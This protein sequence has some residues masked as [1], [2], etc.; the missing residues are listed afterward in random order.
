MILVLVATFMLSGVAGLIYE[1]VW[2]R[3][4]GLF[5]GHSAYAQVIVLVIFLGGMSLGAAAV[6]QRSSRVTRPLFWYAGIEMI[7]GVIGL[8]FHDVFVQVTQLAYDTLFPALG[9]GVELQVAKWGIAALLILPQS[10]LLGMTF[11]MMS[12]GALRAAHIKPEHSGRLLAV[13]YFANSLGAAAGGVLAGFVFIP[14]AGLPGTLY[15]AAILNLVVALV[16]VLA[17]WVRRGR[18]VVVTPAP[19]LGDDGDALAPDALAGDEDSEATPAARR[20]RRVL[21]WVAAGTAVAS[22]VYEIAWI[23][24]LSLVLGAATHSFELML[25]AFIL[26]LALGA[27]WVR[28]RADTF[29]EPV[30]ALGLVQVLMGTLAVATM[31]LYIASFSWLAQLLQALAPS[32]SGYELFTVAKYGLSLVVMLPATF[33][34][35]ITLPLI[36][37]L[38][39][40][41][42]AGER[43]IGTVYAVNTLGSIVGAAFAALVLMP[44]LG[45]KWLLITGAVIDVGFGVALLAGA[46]D[47]RRKATDLRLVAAS[48]A[49]VMA[50][51]IGVRFDRLLLASGVYRY[52]TA[53]ISPEW[54]SMFYADGRTATVSA[55]L[56]RASGQRSLSTNG[57]PDA[58]LPARWML[59]LTPDFERAEL[60]G[61]QS[62]QLLLPLITLAYQPHA[63]RVAAIGQGSGMSS[64]LLLG[65]DSIRAM[66]TIEIEPMMIAGS[67]AIFYPANRRVFTDPRA[68]FII[69]DAKSVFASGGEKY[70]LILSEPSNP[71]V[72]G[73]SGL[74]TDQFYA[75]V[76]TSLSEHGVLGQ[77]LHLY[78]TN[79]FLV[80][81]VLAA[82]HR[83]F[84][85]YVIHMVSS[86]DLLIVA[87][88]SHEMPLPD[89]SVVSQRGI[90]EDLRRVLP[91]TPRALDA[92]WLADREVLGAML[93]HAPYNSDYFPILDL[94]TERARFLKSSATGFYG[95]AQDRF[96]ITHAMHARR[97][98]FGRDTIAPMD[99]A[100]VQALAFGVRLKAAMAKR[101]DS[102]SY[103]DTFMPNAIYQARAIAALGASGTPP[104]D[105]R[106]WISRV[107][108]VEEVLHGGTAGVADSAFYRSVEA[109][110]VRAKAPHGARA[111]V[112][113]M[114]GVAAWDW[115]AVSAQVD[116]LM[117]YERAR[118]PWVGA[119]LLRSAG[120]VARLQL[121]D[122]AGARIVFDRLTPGLPLSPLDVRTAL[123]DGWIRSAAAGEARRTGQ[124]PPGEVPR[125]VVPAPR[126]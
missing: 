53:E 74:F 79:D 20:F 38:L 111:G 93:A 87:S 68:R 110:L 117:H 52:A 34:A 99:M 41:H 19:A 5:V 108:D 102:S 54:R 55:R 95:L 39:L 9:A 15:A 100:R 92:T 69:D 71:W 22:F 49:F 114:R 2:S 86:T 58:S 94:G 23:R 13:L 50:A 82:V 112:A 56:D 103:N 44:L 78:E 90:A 97:E 66:H 98:S 121:G 85:S 91:L 16:V 3:Y 6:A 48:L 45:L 42:G 18:A 33:C 12:A 63:R 37:R 119:S 113:F 60:R 123:L 75:R 72:S 64:H 47:G 116:T 77:W 61:D 109:Y 67:R 21:L 96:S 88:P 126:E 30:R 76:R 118:A 57:K 59:P 27:W 40:A 14:M 46:A 31:P 73:V 17:E 24:M 28:R 120:V 125:N 83:N 11:P 51:A 81:S 80:L 7:A 8:V 4:L 124:L 115:K 65:S 101:D 26:G 105:W 122:V 1:S 89:W 32:P 106:A 62:S 43:A 104:G 70:D 107:S 29:V 10:V 25:S 84:P 36:T 35:G